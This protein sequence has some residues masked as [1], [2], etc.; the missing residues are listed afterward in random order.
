MVRHWPGGV[1]VPRAGAGHQVNL[2]GGRL[3]GEAWTDRLGGGAQGLPRAGFADGQVRRE[4]LGVLPAIRRASV[5]LA[6][7]ARN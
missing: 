6:S 3:D 1:G 4:R 7:A 2:C 5:G